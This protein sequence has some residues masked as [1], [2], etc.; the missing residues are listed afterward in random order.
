MQLFRFENLRCS[1]THAI[2]TLAGTELIRLCMPVGMVPNESS[3]VLA[4]L[5]VLRY[6]HLYR[7]LID[8]VYSTIPQ[9]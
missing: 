3:I 9:N 6:P 7:Q 2:Y 4:I 5:L 8:I 1:L